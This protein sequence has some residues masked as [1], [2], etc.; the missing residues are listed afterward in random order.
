VHYQLKVISNNAEVIAASDESGDEGFD[1]VA[2]ARTMKEALAVL[3]EGETVALEAR[4]LGPA[5]DFAPLREYG[6]DA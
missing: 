6:R 4:Y 2:I 1:P 5:P 3:A